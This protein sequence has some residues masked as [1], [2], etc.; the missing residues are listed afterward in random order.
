MQRATYTL[1]KAQG[2]QVRIREGVTH[3]KQQNNGVKTTMKTTNEQTEKQT[4]PIKDVRRACVPIVLY[5][6]A[7]PAATIRTITMELNGQSDKTPILQHDIIRGL[8]GLNDA[9]RKALRA[10]MNDDDPALST[11]NPVDCLARL[12]KVTT[13]DNSNTPLRKSVI[14]MHNA[15]KGLEDVSKIQAIWNLRDPFAAI[16]ATL[17][18]LA[19]SAQVPL[20]LRQ[21]IVTLSDPLPTPEEI[22]AICEDL[23][24]AAR[25]GGAEI[26]P[27]DIRKDGRL[28]DTLTGLSGFG[29]KQVFS[30]SLR[31][32]GINERVLNERKR[33]LV[34][35]TPGLSIWEGKETLDD[36][37]GLAN[38]K[39][40]YKNV[41]TSGN[42][43]V[44]GI[45]FIDEIEKML[46][47]IGGD[48]SG[49]TQDQLGC[50]LREMQD[51]N[52]SGSILLSPPGCLHADT[53]IYDPVART[54]RSVRERYEAGRAFNVRAMDASGA[55][56]TA[57]AYA[58]RRY[59][60]AKMLCVEMANGQTV[61]VTEHHRFWNG[62][63]FVTAGAIYEAFFSPTRH[64]QRKQYAACRL[65]SISDDC[66]ATP[67]QGAIRLF[68]TPSSSP[69]YCL[70]DSCLGGEQLRPYPASGPAFLQPQVYARR[71]TPA[72]CSSDDQGETD[73]HSPSLGCAHPSKLDCW[74]PTGQ[75][76]E[77]VRQSA[78]LAAACGLSA[79]RTASAAIL[80]PQIARLHTGQQLP[81]PSLSSTAHGS[82]SL[83]QSL[84]A[85]VEIV[86]IK[87]AGVHP[88]YDF[89]VPVFENYEACGLVHHNCGKSNFV[90]A[91][92]KLCSAPVISFDLGAAKNSLVGAS[93]ERMRAMMQV[94]RAVTQGKGII[95][96]TCNQI[97]SLPP[98]LRRRFKL[99]TFFIDLPDA[100]ERAGIWAIWLGKLGLDPKQDRPLDDG[101]TGA[102]IA[103]CCEIAYRT[104]QSLLEASNF[105]VPVSK[106]AADQLEA[107]R[108]MA[109]GKFISASYPGPYNRNRKT[110]EPSQSAERA[111]TGFDKE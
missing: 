31:K 93:E 64:E 9:G 20:E 5:E 11:G 75:L 58:P 71:H 6:T 72:L 7:D 104:G 51:N 46:A 1:P 38:L 80:R 86:N 49:T 25:K 101:W 62:R 14:F 100:E 22:G 54:I 63:S 81:P 19:T 67:P 102:E 29:V 48:S 70:A 79:S 91:L 40:F 87:P 88:F 10:I 95:I 55:I 12:Y 103:A 28:H 39:A 66:R 35:Q 36:L 27:E 2:H 61:T 82:F 77:G 78:S 85:S 4:H 42:T 44:R 74:P 57:L 32:T 47:G 8:D 94:F 97:A 30:M 69:S 56:V 41:L 17:V 60:P 34:E 99:G 26:N 33:K 37:A 111:F 68:E 50:I 96:A 18:L 109:D 105:V 98:E 59:A 43:P 45:G 52:I 83:P 84:G 3:S 15:H 76:T 65:P 110:G 106:S 90:K 89:H 13:D 53:P 107:L 73:K 21:D 24:K 108:R 92:G 16:G 23:A